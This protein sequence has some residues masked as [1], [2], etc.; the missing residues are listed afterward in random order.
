MKY[1]PSVFDIFTLIYFTNSTTH[2]MYGGIYWFHPSPMQKNYFLPFK[3]SYISE[4]ALDL[5]YREKKMIRKMCLKELEAKF[6]PK[7][8]LFWQNL[9]PNSGQ[10]KI[11]CQPSPKISIND[12]KLCSNSK[13]SPL[14]SKRT[15]KKILKISILPISEYLKK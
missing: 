3:P 9:V 11:L 13:F 6:H 7:I 15:P 4:L 12:Y 14:D 10:C 2:S 8:A 5:T 1:L